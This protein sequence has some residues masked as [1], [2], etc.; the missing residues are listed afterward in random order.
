MLNIVCNHARAYDWKHA[1]CLGHILPSN[2]LFPTLQV[3]VS[4]LKAN[5]ACSV[6]LTIDHE[7]ESN[8]VVSS[9]ASTS[10]LVIK[11]ASN[12]TPIKGAVPL[13]KT[14][15]VPRDGG[16]SFLMS[17]FFGYSPLDLAAL[18]SWHITWHRQVRLM[19]TRA[20]TSGFGLLPFS[21]NPT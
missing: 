10:G 11:E 8:P 6:D 18:L 19:K 9:P 16:T 17:P 1:A 7:A 15:P 13:A 5:K 20:T 12:N 14:L 21:S 3:G 4:G 2:S